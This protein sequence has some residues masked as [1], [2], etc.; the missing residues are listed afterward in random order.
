MRI[1]RGLLNFKSIK[2]KIS[3][4][5]TTFLVVV[6]VVI[7]LIGIA[8]TKIAFQRQIENDIRVLTTQAAQMIEGEL[9][10][11]ENYV[12][13]LGTTYDLTKEMKAPDRGAFFDELA[14]KHGFIEFLYSDAKGEA[15]KLSKT[16]DA[17][18]I[19]S[20]EYFQ[21]SIQG[22]VF[23]SDILV[24]MVSKQKIIV[25]SA[26]HYD[27]GKIVGVI[28]GIKS[29][30]FIS[31]ICSGFEWGESGILFVYD[32]DSSILGHTNPAVVNSEFNIMASAATKP[33]Y[34]DLRSSLQTKFFT[35]SSERESIF[36]MVMI[37]WPDSIIF[38]GG[39]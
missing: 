16:G 30:D 39:M 7:L 35:I 37:K 11:T 4:S 5:V 14:K 28:A 21:K 9:K 20:R 10:I 24:D 34:E 1:G 18:N 3:V 8:M 36:L 23:T 12:A 17:L 25:V 32:T 33:E 13:N 26:P 6:C 22:E 19:A 38:R 15:Q 29:I 2:T 31:N 27:K